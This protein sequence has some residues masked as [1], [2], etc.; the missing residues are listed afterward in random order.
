MSLGVPVFSVCKCFILLLSEPFC[1]SIMISFLS[2]CGLKIILFQY[3]HKHLCIQNSKSDILQKSKLLI[4]LVL[5]R[6]GKI[7]HFSD[8][9]WKVYEYIPQPLILDIMFTL[10]TFFHIDFYLHIIFFILSLPTTLYFL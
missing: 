6:R 1:Y 7:P 4:T 10:G 2:Y 3:G 8:Y 5:K 9:S